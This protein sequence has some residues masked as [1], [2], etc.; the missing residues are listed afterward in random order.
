MGLKVSVIPDSSVYAMM[1]K[2]SKV[3][4]STQ[5]IMANGGLIAHSGAY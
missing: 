4:I 1:Q 3:I 2:V 5:G